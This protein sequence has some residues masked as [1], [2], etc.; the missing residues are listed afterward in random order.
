MPK[1]PIDYAKTILYKIV[2]NDLKII[3]CYVGTTIN[4]NVVII[5]HNI[6]YMK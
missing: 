2:C 1:V 5:K 3:D 6:K 4:L